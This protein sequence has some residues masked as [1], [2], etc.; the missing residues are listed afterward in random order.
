M[1]PPT[2]FALDDAEGSRLGFP[3]G[4][5]TL[6]V[7]VKED[8]ETCNLTLPLVQ[9]LHQAAGEG[10]ATW[11]IAQATADIPVLRA[12]HGLTMPLLDDD[13]LDVSY[14]AEIDTVPSLF[15]YDADGACTLQ[16]FGFDKAEWQALA[17]EAMDLA[18]K[19]AAAP[20]IDWEALP[21][22]RPGCGAR[23]VEPGVSE[24]L[25]ARR[26]GA[27]LARLVEIA[28][29][30]DVHEF[31]FEQGFSDG[32]PV[33][34]PTPERVW[35]MLQGTQ[36][37]PQE[38]V[39]S[40]PPNLAPASV[41]K[42]AINAVMAGAKPEYLPPI[43]T[44][45]EAV[46]TDEF[47]IHGVMATTMGASPA[48]IVNGPIRHRLG[49]NMQLGALGQ[50]N[51]ANATIG[52]AL[53]LVIRNLGGARPGGTE[54]S[55]LGS[56]AK[57]TLCFP[58][59]EEESPWEPLHVERGFQAEDDVVTV[60][61]V[62]AGPQIIMDQSSRTARALA[63]TI[64]LGLQGVHDPKAPTGDVLLVVAPEHAGTL[65]REGWTKAR[66]RE[67]IQ[68][69]TA[70]PLRE[71]LQDADSG[72]GIPPRAAAEQDLDQLVSKF[73][74]GDSIQ[75][76]VAGSRAGMLSVVFGGWVSGPMG[77]QPVSRKIRP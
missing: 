41:E 13:A 35:R 1:K 2:A 67:R 53:R 24:R 36:R 60:F 45:V 61:A 32:L 50:G 8:C 27:L 51:R 77:S 46:C 30:N 20:A 58:E 21:E 55:T 74:S 29:H 15:L 22:S 18:G 69:I 31:I 16:T 25:E 38:I 6:L 73:R 63:G 14:D 47:N 72:A 3:S 66:L 11:V 44:A 7:L 10:L 43:L 39:A 5:P 65:A 54:R 59:W 57:F 70:R 9:A 34:P 4:R 64:G 71:R 26:S 37:D 52:R 48:V 17:S 56:P 12:R 23:N 49:M 42:I 28:A 40:V 19:P 75:I 62:T 68:E 33:V 76:L